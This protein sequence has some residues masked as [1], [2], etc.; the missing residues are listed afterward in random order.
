MSSNAPAIV[1]VRRSLMLSAWRRCASSFMAIWSS[2]SDSAPSTSARRRSR[3][4]VDRAHRASSSRRSLMSMPVSSLRAARSLMCPNSISTS[5]RA[6]RSGRPSARARKANTSGLGRPQLQARS[7]RYGW[8]AFAANMLRAVWRTP[9][10]SRTAI[11]VPSRRRTPRNDPSLSMSTWPRSMTACT[12]RD[13]Y[14]PWPSVRS[15][16]SGGSSPSMRR[17]RPAGS[18]SACTVDVQAAG[19]W[20]STALARMSRTPLPSGASRTVSSHWAPRW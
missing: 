19:R 11:V 5:R 3:S 14:P 13:G 4:G 7:S 8:S 2:V 17:T 12:C 18:V 20:M 16:Q 1:P 15:A 6:T 10:A 9:S